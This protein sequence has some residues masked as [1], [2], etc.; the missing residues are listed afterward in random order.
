MQ[1]EHLLRL[2]PDLRPVLG[3]GAMPLAALLEGR[4]VWRLAS[5]AARTLTMPTRIRRSVPTFFCSVAKTLVPTS[6]AS[7]TTGTPN[8]MLY[9]ARRVAIA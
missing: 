2:P 3:S 1:R 8:Q 5:T 9:L 4:K 6:V 7:A